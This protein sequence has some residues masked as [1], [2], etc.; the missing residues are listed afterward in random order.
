VVQEAKY[1]VYINEEV[2]E[3]KEGEMPLIVDLKK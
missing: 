3:D 1:N 2:S